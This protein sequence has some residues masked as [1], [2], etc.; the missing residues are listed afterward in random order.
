[1][2]GEAIR[3]ECFGTGVPRNDLQLELWGLVSSII[4][5]ICDLALFSE[6]RGASQVSFSEFLYSIGGNGTLFTSRLPLFLPG[7]SI[8]SN[9]SEKSPFVVIKD[10]RLA[11][12]SVRVYAR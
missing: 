12:A 10:I 8:Q 9:R 6:I 4:F 3:R 5:S 2:R 1:M 7:S 11:S